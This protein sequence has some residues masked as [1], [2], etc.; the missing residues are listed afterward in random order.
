MRAGIRL[1]LSMLAMFACAAAVTCCSG[2]DASPE[3]T[4]DGTTIPPAPGTSDPAPPPPAPVPPGLNLDAGG[5]EAASP[6]GPAPRTMWAVDDTNRLVR[7]T[8][9]QPGKVTTLA[10]SGLAPGERV[11]AVDVRPADGK[12]YA[13]ATTSRLY[14]ID[15]TS[16]VAKAVGAKAFAPA[17]AGA[18]FGFD[19]NPVADKLRVHSDSEQNLRVDPTMGTATNDVGL[20][21]A[22]GDPNEGQSPNLI[23]TAYTNS[24]SPAPTATVL[25]A[26]DSTR[27]LLTKLTTPNDGKVT[28]IGAL[29]VDI[30]DVG[31]FDIFGGASGTGATKPVEAYAVLMTGGKSGLYAIDLATGTATLKGLIGHPTAVHG[32][33]IQP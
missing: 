6:A 24:V 21:F 29:G 7:F 27:N 18:A 25:Y 14:L 28:T 30:T 20:A 4:E 12:L 16:G 1:G 26:I 22:V 5:P 15:S 2:A 3:A 19:V 32:L 23:A 10:L 17:L 31:G 33:A 11:L 8:P 13:L 9:E